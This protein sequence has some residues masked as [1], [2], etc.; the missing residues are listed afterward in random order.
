MIGSVASL[1]ESPTN[2]CAK[3]IYLEAFVEKKNFLW[4]FCG[5]NFKYEK[6]NFIALALIRAS[7]EE[8]AA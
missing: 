3:R 2:L 1:R 6:N 4:E 5:R 7:C 8:V